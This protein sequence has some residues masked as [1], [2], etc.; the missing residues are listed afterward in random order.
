MDPT[1]AQMAFVPLMDILRDLVHIFKD[2]SLTSDKFL[3]LSLEYNNMVD[4]IVASKTN[5][6][7]SDALALAA[8]IVDQ[9]KSISTNLDLSF[10][11]RQLSALKSCHLSYIINQIGG[12]FTV[13]V[14][15]Q[16]WPDVWHTEGCPFEST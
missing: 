3:A 11:I 15:K 8:F 2:G 12:A 10:A 6:I 5:S 13:S 16:Y 4:I 14:D 1:L 9:L 7:P